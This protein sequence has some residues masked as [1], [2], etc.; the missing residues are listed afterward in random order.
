VIS[1]DVAY[2]S[3]LSDL[4]DVLYGSATTDPRIPLPA[5][6]LSIFEENSILQIIDN[7]DGTWTAIGPSSAI[8]MLDSIT[9]QIDWPSAVFI[10]ANS[11]SIHSL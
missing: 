1:A 11:Y 6:I 4:E 3:A 10:D 2:S 9:F 8:I 5:E 7:G